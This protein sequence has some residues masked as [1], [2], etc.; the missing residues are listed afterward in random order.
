MPTWPCGR[1]SSWL[2]CSAYHLVGQHQECWGKRD[3]EGLGGLQVEDQVELRRL[4][5]RQVGGLGPLED[6]VHIDGSAAVEVERAWPIGQE[7]ARL[8]KWPDV[9]YCRQAA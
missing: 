7:A 5:H 1:P 8:H 9:V 2:T 4:L 3:S 6:F